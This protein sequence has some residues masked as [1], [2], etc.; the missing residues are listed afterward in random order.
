[1]SEKP[2]NRQLL[3]HCKGPP[4][5]DQAEQLRKAVADVPDPEDSIDYPGLKKSVG[6][7]ARMARDLHGRT[8]NRGGVQITPPGIRRLIAN[9]AGYLTD[10]CSVHDIDIP[11]E[12]E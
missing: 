3:G 11:E 8:A 6:R 12:S 7:I 1:M 5:H 4:I 2:C 10:A 9:L